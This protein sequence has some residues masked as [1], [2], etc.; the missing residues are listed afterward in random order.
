MGVP[1]RGHVVDEV[2]VGAAL[3]VDEEAP[4]PRSICGGSA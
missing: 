4:H 2:D 3:R 1:D